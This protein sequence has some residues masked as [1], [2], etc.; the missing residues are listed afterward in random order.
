MFS[1]WFAGSVLSALSVVGL[2]IVIMGVLLWWRRRTLL[3]TPGTFKARLLPGE[4]GSASHGT[5]I[6]VSYNETS[7]E[8]MTLVS[9]SPIPRWSGARHRLEIDRLGAGRK[10]PWV[11]VRLMA[12]SSS[13]VLEMED[14]N[15]SELST[16]LESGPSVGIG[17]WRDEPVRRQRRK[18]F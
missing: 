14:V 2:I 8:L 15:L 7:V 5:R 9:L 18:Y 4:S 10:E 6:I 11:R 16:W 13:R 1:G 17:I 12:G 3:R